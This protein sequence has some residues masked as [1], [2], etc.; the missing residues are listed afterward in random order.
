MEMGINQNYAEITMTAQGQDT[1][2]ATISGGTLDRGKYS[3]Y[4][5]AQDNAG[6][7]KA[8][9]VYSFEVSTPTF[10]SRSGTISGRK[11]DS[12]PREAGPAKQSSARP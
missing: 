11:I 2:Q 3:Y 10:I 5:A 1:Y 8:T 12:P 4:I 7:W 9:P 6:N